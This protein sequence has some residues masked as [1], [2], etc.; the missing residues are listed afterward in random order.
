M[1][2][3]CQSLQGVIL[4]ANERNVGSLIRVLHL[5]V[6]IYANS[7][8]Y[9]TFRWE[10]IRYWAT[11]NTLRVWSF[12]YI[13]TGLTASVP[14]C[15]VVH[16]PFCWGCRRSHFV[17]QPVAPSM[18]PYIHIHSEPIECV[19][20]R[21]PNCVLDERLLILNTFTFHVPAQRKCVFPSFTETK[22]RS[23]RVSNDTWFPGG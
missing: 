2:K 15:H 19:K 4:Q 13:Q 11:K 5:C 21:C 6:W 20:Q 22:S 7:D 16:P 1:Y 8:K 14:D 3:S 9:T 18:G 12:L 17:I 10:R 23:V